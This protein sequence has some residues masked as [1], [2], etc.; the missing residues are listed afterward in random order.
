MIMNRGVRIIAIFWGAIMFAGCSVGPNYVRP[1]PPKTNTYISGALPG[2]TASAGIK[3]GEAQRFIVGADIPAQWWE[4]FHSRGLDTLIRKSLAES[5]TMAQA[6]AKLREARENANALAGATLYPAVSGSFSAS[7]QKTQAFFPGQ[8]NIVSN[9]YQASLNVSYLLDI[10]GSSRRQVEALRAEV[11]F[12]SF[13]LDAAYL[14]LTSSVVIAA[15]NE[16]AL[17]E[18]ISATEEILSTQEKYLE[19]LEKQ[20][21]LGG[22][23]RQDVLSQRSQV[24]ETRSSIS[25][26][27]KQLAQNRHQL[28][29]LAGELPN[30]ENELPEFRLDELTLPENL[31]VSLPSEI[32]RQR[33][34]IAAAQ[35]LLHAASAGVGVATANLYPQITL[36]GSFGP[37]ASVFKDLFKSDNVLW[38]LGG[39]LLQPIFN[40]GEL[41][42]KKRAA[43]AVYDQA[44]AQ[45]RSVVLNA[46]GEVADTLR[47]L[48]ADANTLQAQANAQ[49]AAK[50]SLGLIE[51][52]LK[53]GAVSYL[54]LLNGEQ[55][56]ARARLS[57]VSARASR[58]VDTAMLFKALGGGWINKELLW[59]NE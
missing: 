59:L 28:A 12:E 36:S 21:E 48:E 51:D 11:D 26:L 27:Q 25:G 18:E 53:A 44:R 32:T 30:K 15:V 8:K 29:I 20:F 42:A 13:E 31:P 41:N 47:A 10:F 14:A 24:E 4:V 43:L 45:Y 34:D 16:A 50:E 58:L 5:P 3:G 1:E 17:R 55:Q 37:E 57:L 52:Q 19:R 22:V 9:S 6:E 40:G 39:N 46:F 38:S 49:R 7:R 54:V 23:A 33:P 2:K 35:A 56:Y